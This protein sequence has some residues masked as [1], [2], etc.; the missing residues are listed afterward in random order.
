[1]QAAASVSKDPRCLRCKKNK[2]S[3]MGTRSAKA[4][5]EKERFLSGGGGSEILK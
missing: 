3:R 4:V 1:M 5:S 2:K